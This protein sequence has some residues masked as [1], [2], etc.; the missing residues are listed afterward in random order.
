[1]G[2]SV[3]DGV[4]SYMSV[5]HAVEHILELGRVTVL[6]KC[7]VKHAY[8]NVPEAPAGDGV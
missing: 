7:N 3:N 1:M 2:R 5:D 4:M 8:R 6:A